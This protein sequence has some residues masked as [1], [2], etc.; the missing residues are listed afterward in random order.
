MRTTKL[1]WE[2]RKREKKH[3]EETIFKEKIDKDFGEFTE[4]HRP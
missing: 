1:Q 4:T 3:G 2:F